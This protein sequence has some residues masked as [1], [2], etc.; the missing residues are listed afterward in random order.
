VIPKT[1]GQFDDCRR[2]RWRAGG[3]EELGGLRALNI[4]HRCTA[5]QAGTTRRAALA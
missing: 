3:D 2:E 4:H 5:I 1:T